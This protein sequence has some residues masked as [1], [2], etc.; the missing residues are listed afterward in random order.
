MSFFSCQWRSQHEGDTL[1]K[2]IQERVNCQWKKNADAKSAKLE[3]IL[4]SDF[5]RKEEKCSGKWLSQLYSPKE[6]SIWRTSIDK[7]TYIW[8]KEVGKASRNTLNRIERAISND[9]HPHPP[10]DS[11]AKK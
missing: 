7:N 10:P 5:C 2:W 11:I 6:A 4:I 1:S 3:T 9:V 8:T